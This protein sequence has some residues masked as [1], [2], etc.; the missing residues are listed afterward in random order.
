MGREGNAVLSPGSLG[1]AGRVEIRVR[2]AVGN[3]RTY[4]SRHEVVLVGFAHRNDNDDGIYEPDERVNVSRIVVKNEGGMPT[5]PGRALSIQLAR[6]EWVV[7]DAEQIFLPKSLGPD[8]ELEL[9]GA[10]GF[11]IGNYVPQGPSDPLGSDA[12][13]HL[14]AALVEAPARRG[15]GR[16]GAA[17]GAPHAARQA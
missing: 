13:I 3:A 14:D 7:P 16:R 1:S 11:R 6:N 17:R 2:D 15:Q 8:E 5:P 12:H 9:E 4:A 10:L